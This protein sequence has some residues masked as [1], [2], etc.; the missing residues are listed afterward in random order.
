MVDK[1]YKI[2]AGNVDEF[3]RVEEAIGRLEGQFAVVGDNMTAV[4]CAGDYI[5]ISNANEVV[6]R[7]VLGQETDPLFTARLQRSNP[8]LVGLVV[9][10]KGYEQKYLIHLVRKQ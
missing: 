7:K 9:E 4:N 8:D 10:G 2:T 3:K 6:S 5:D 1:K